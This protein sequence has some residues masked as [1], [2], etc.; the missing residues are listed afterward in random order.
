[1]PREDIAGM[2]A[3][4]THVETTR[5][6]ESVSLQQLETM[7]NEGEHIIKQI[8]E[9]MLHFLNV[10]PDVVLPSLQSMSRQLNMIKTCNAFSSNLMMFG[11]YAFSKKRKGMMIAV[12]PSAISRRKTEITGRRKHPGGRPLLG[13]LNRQPAPHDL[14]ECVKRNIRLGGGHLKK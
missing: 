7:K 1:M 5:A 8:A 14:G 12:Q 13:H 11:K 4:S 2:S 10:S 9:K 6:M 3:P